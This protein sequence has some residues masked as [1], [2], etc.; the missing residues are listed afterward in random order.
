MASMAQLPR[1]SHENGK[2]EAWSS[3]FLTDDSI[4]YIHPDNLAPFD[5]RTQDPNI[6]PWADIPASDEFESEVCLYSVSMT[7]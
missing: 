1:P 6:A 3:F 7:Q 2:Q 5:P 4:D